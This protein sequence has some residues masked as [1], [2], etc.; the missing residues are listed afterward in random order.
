[1]HASSVVLNI[2]LQYIVSSTH[3]CIQQPQAIIPQLFSN[4]VYAHIH[5]NLLVITATMYLQDSASYI[6]VFLCYVA[7][8]A[9]VSSYI[10]LFR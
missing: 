5:M 2:V 6:T 1:M 10:L 7:M 4:I 8:W 3:L 9:I